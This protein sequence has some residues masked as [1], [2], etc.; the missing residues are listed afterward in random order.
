MR[1]AIST[2]PTETTHDGIK[3][4]RRSYRKH[5]V[6]FFDESLCKIFHA[7]F[8]HT[9]K[10]TRQFL[11]SKNLLEFL[12][13]NPNIMLHFTEREKHAPFVVKGNNYFVNINSYI[14]F[15]KKI[16]SSTEGRAQAF[17]GQHINYE[18]VMPTELRSKVLNSA[19]LDE[20]LPVLEQMDES[21]ITRLHKLLSTKNGIKNGTESMEG[22]ATHIKN[23]AKSSRKRTILNAEYPKIQLETLKEYKQFLLNNLD[24]NET[25]IQN[26]VDGKIDHDGNKISGTP[27]EIARLRKS[28]CLIFGLEFI[29][30][31]REGAA[32]QKRFDIL[33][34]MADGRNEY[35]L[36]E[37]KSPSGKV[38]D[39]REEAN[40]NGGKSTTYSL[41]DDISRALPQIA[42]Y[43]GLLRDASNV[44]WQQIGYSPGEVVKSI[45]LVG[46]R[47]KNDLVWDDNYMHLKNGLSSTIE[48][49]TY[50]DLLERLDATIQ[51]LA[52]NL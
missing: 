51:N 38:F 7:K 42:S 4:L 11:Y 22:F 43:K 33:T 2:I 47:P 44:E 21:S 36:I 23:S 10:R 15:C 17:F 9:K 6:V 32:S 26:W 1:P 25:F 20:L 40:R 28:R 19:T 39:V 31:K 24:K 41:S 18:D 30:H 14:D 48:I 35:V 52:E 5:V 16:S 13:L 45:I 37:L 27:E 12:V 8:N 34:R 46:T 50:T 3:Y 49:M 29:N